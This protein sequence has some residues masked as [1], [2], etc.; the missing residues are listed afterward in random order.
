MMV[1]FFAIKKTIAVRSEC[2]EKQKN[3]ELS[4]NL[5]A[6][7]SEIRIDLAKLERVMGQKND[8]NKKVIDLLLE[9]ITEYCNKN[10][11]TLRDIPKAMYAKDPNFNIETNVI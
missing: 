9:S 11:C 5:E 7:V 2:E 8:T 4:Q 10:G 6:R 1:Y 3:L